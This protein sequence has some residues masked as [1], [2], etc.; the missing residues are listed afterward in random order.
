MAGKQVGW[1]LDQDLYK[2]IWSVVTYA[3]AKA[4]ESGD[5]E[6]EQSAEGVRQ[7]LDTVTDHGKAFTP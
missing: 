1:E 3:T 7:I 5:H 6:M 4:M 2:R